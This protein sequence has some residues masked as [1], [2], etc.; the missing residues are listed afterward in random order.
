MPDEATQRAPGLQPRLPSNSLLRMK[1]ARAVELGQDPEAEMNL[2]ILGRRPQLDIAPAPS[3]TPD[4]DTEGPDEPIVVQPISMTDELLGQLLVQ[5]KVMTDELFNRPGKNRSI[6]TTL[7]TLSADYVTVASWTIPPGL[8]GQLREIAFT[9]DTPETAQW[10][11]T[12]G[13]DT[14]WTDLVQLNPLSIPFADSNRLQ[15]NL[16]VLL[17]M[18]SDGAATIVSDASIS[19]IERDA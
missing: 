3:V 5:F 13:N 19:G 17:E 16:E 12:I 8:V 1:I 7:S 10:K 9:S 15:E 11:L 4:P 18:K 6:V 2:T 14:Q